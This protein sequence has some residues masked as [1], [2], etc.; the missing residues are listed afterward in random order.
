MPSS[1]S[2]PWLPCCIGQGARSTWCRRGRAACDRRRGTRCAW[3]GLR[4]RHDCREQDSG[5]FASDACGRGSRGEAADARS[6]DDEIVGFAGGLRCPGLIPL[7]AVAQ[8]MRIVK[9]HHVSAHADE[10][11]GIVAGSFFGSVGRV[12]ERQRR[13]RKSAL[14]MLRATPLRKSRRQMGHP[15]PDLVVAHIKGSAG[16]LYAARG[17]KGGV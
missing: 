17:S 9:K 13:M 16:E 12:A 10:G 4:N 3:R 1:T 8:L 6:D 2:S 15:F 7:L 14:P 5:P 11:R